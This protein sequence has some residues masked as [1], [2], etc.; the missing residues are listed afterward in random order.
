MARDWR[1][2]EEERL[3]FDIADIY[4]ITKPV[5]FSPYSRRAVKI[6]L[7][8]QDSDAAELLRD[9]ADLTPY[10]LEENSLKD[11]LLADR[12][13][14]WNIRIGEV[15]L[16]EY[17]PSGEGDCGF[18][19]PYGDR[20]I[21]RYEFNKQK[22]GDFICPDTIEIPCLLAAEK[23][24]E[25]QLITLI[26]N[27]K[28]KNKC[29]SLSILRPKE[30][31]EQIAGHKSG[32]REI[33]FSNVSRLGDDRA[34]RIFAKERLRTQGDIERLLHCFN[35]PEYDCK[36]A[37][38]S[39][40]RKTELK[41][42]KRYSGELSYGACCYSCREQLLYGKRRVLPCCHIRFS[43]RAKFLADYADYVLFFLENRYPDFLWAGVM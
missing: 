26:T 31:E 2:I 22:N 15:K 33:F 9:A 3:L 5:V 7:P 39:D 12:Q 19:A 17:N 38:V 37:G 1:Y 23:D 10:L 30:Y 42:I 6:Q 8:I 14:L 11:K 25:R 24:E 40:S 27:R 36:F 4:H 43:G 13:L 20:E 16:P 41:S 21:Y 32:N 18:V 29:R 35:I 28:L 34:G